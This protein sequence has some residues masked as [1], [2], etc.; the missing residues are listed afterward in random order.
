VFCRPG[1]QSILRSCAEFYQGAFSTHRKLLIIR[2]GDRLDWAFRNASGNWT[3]KAF[4]SEGPNVLPEREDG[5]QAYQ[6]DTPITE[7]GVSKAKSIGRALENHGISEVYSSPSLRCIQTAS[8]LLKGMGQKSIKIKIEPGL[9]EW[10]GF[11]SYK[12]NIPTWIRPGA[13][14]AKGFPVDPTYQ[15]IIAAGKLDYRESIKDFYLRSHAVAEQILDRNSE[16]RSTVLVVAHGANVD[17]CSRLLC[18]NS[19]APNLAQF[20]DLLNKIPYLALTCVNEY[21][22]AKSSIWQI[23]KPPQATFDW[24]ILTAPLPDVDE[25]RMFA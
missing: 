11:R 22:H 3:E 25:K 14:E 5:L 18:G 19:E 1:E 7:A 8:A 13:Y 12:P 23:A 15:P 21:R 10:C 9:F 24:Q 20:Y 17:S 16:C 2:H 6:L 4:G